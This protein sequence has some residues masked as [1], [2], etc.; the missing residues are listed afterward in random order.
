MILTSI[1]AFI[2]AVGLLVTIHDKTSCFVGTVRVNNTTKLDWSACRTYQVVLVGDNPNRET[3]QAGGTANEAL[4]VFGLVFVERITIDQ[5]IE[6]VA[7]FVVFAWIG[8]NNIQ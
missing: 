3:A 8:A 4:T 6:N 5:A 7:D 2:F 1:L